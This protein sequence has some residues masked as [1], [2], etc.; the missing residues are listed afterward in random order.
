MTKSQ[1][2]KRD[3]N[4]FSG[5]V[6]NA[7]LDIDDVIV[8]T[9]SIKSGELDSQVTIVKKICYALQEQTSNLL[10]IADKK[11]EHLDYEYEDM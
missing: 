6:A 4:A 8:D 3:L 10:Y 11:I 9:D 7:C 5:D 2:L 1:Q